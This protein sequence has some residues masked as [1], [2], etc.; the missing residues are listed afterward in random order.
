L[1]DKKS[2]RKLLRITIIQSL[3]SLLDLAAVMLIGLIGALAVLGVQSN[4]SYINYII[5]FLRL[6][7]LEFQTQI[8]L[9]AS[10]AAGLLL[11]KTLLSAYV[12]WKTTRYYSFLA[13]EIST[14]LIEKFLK[15]TIDKIYL[16]SSQRNLYNLCSGI[17]I[18]VVGVISSISSLISDL[19][20][21]LLMLITLFVSNPEMATLTFIVFTSAAVILHY[22]VGVKSRTL[23]ETLVPLNIKSSQSILNSIEGYREIFVSNSMNKRIENISELLRNTAKL[24]SKQAFLPY[25][26]KYFI[27][28]VL[29]FSIALFSF[30]QI[31]LT[32]AV[33][34]ASALALFIAA[35]SRIAPAALRVQQGISSVMNGYG[36]G[37]VSLELH[38]LL[39]MESIEPLITKARTSDS[40]VKSTK[41][42]VP[43]VLLK[44]VHFGY[45]KNKII[46]SGINFEVMRGQNV[47]ILGKSGRG[48]STLL[49]L[50]LGLVIPN[51]GTVELFG[52]SPRTAIESGKNRISLVSQRP[53]IF[54]GTLFDNICDGDSK[55]TIKAIRDALRFVDMLEFAENLPKGFNTI[56]SESGNN[57][58]GGQRQRISLARA[59]MQEPKLLIL[60]EATSALDLTTESLI[61]ERLNKNKKIETK[62]VISHKARNISV[63]DKVGV[64]TKNN[65]LFGSV[66][67]IAKKNKQFAKLLLN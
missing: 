59:I 51:Q 55:Y 30:V 33:Q 35:S 65:F 6:E 11:S 43:V 37:K 57:L 49:D 23:A 17:S 26:S 15:Q 21:I 53:F 66:E 7:T 52:E 38:E 36:A 22:I 29:V 48:K 13:A 61:F 40:L 8:M 58:S 4:T 41:K 3:L 25:I 34:S 62:I 27:E 54:E 10:L 1:L 14:G 63:Y 19:V 2:K 12:V 67:Q 9:L 46:L 16:N 24:T 45:E 31:S 60:D 18:I 64:F 28:I 20:L 42:E 56:L 39:Q 5:K 44:D 47:L 32:N 50:I